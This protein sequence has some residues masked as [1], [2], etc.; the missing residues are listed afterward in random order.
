MATCGRKRTL[1]DIG[2]LVGLL[3]AAGCVLAGHLLGGGT[4]QGLLDPTAA[5]IVVGGSLCATMVSM[6]L[7]R[8][9]QIP[10]HVILAMRQETINEYQFVEDVCRWHVLAK[11]EGPVALEEHAKKQPDHLLR[12]ALQQKANGR[13]D[14]DLRQEL[15]SMIWSEQF[16]A[17]SASEV[18]EAAG[19]FAPTFGIVATVMGLIDVLGKLSSGD[20]AALGAAVSTAF[21]GTFYGISSANIFWLPL[22]K[23]L[24]TKSKE[25]DRQQ[26]LFVEAVSLI[27]RASGPI[28]IRQR[29]YRII[30]PKKADEIRGVAS[31]GGAAANAA[32][33]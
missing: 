22:G 19:G 21:L 2:V 29:L 23:K 14:E 31:A 7:K 30:D 1:V 8:M 27:S 3:G 20:A 17:K 9:L 28:E 15:L 26:R 11:K 5:L 24:K 13:K 4:I 32:G 33:G 12:F 16:Q 25:R 6:G 10:G 18:F